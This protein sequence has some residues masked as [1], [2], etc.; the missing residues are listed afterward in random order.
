MSDF[1]YLSV[2]IAIIIG[3]GI[4]HLLLSLGRILGD[5]KRLNVGVP[6]LIW[7]GNILLMLISFWWWGINLREIEE[8]VY[9]QLLFLLFDVSL[10]CLLAAL[11]F[12]VTIPD[13]FDLGEYF[14]KKRKPFYL[15]LILLA[16]ADPVT[17][18]I[19]G[20][21]HLIELGWGYLHWMLV[22]CLVGGIAALRFDSPR[23]DLG[24]SIYW[25]LSLMVFILTWQ[26]SVAS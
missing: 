4:A 1:E 23:F 6:H 10:W 2:L 15:I 18:I 22:C 13:D 3:I 16:F 24:F 12:P 25:G 7:T 17:S 20:T 14:Q 26:A 8:W 9:I 19:L 11:L 5:V 21:E